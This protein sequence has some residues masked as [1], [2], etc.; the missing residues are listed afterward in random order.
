MTIVITQIQFIK[1]EVWITW[2]VSL[3]FYKST[4]SV[5]WVWTTQEPVNV[6]A[7]RNNRM[8]Y[9]FFELFSIK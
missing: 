2:L 9:W 6:I 3:H 5:P 1:T 4:K 7:L 8:V